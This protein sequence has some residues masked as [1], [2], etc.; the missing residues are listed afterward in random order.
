MASYR[1]VR[2]VARQNIAV[3]LGLV[4]REGV[5]RFINTKPTGTLYTHIPTI[6]DPMVGYEIELVFL[7]KVKVDSTPSK[8]REL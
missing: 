8:S 4:N 6:T 3:K 1:P 5:A 2:R 7:R